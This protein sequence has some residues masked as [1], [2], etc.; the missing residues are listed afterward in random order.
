MDESDFENS[1]KHSPAKPAVAIDNKH[2]YPT[3]VLT[4]SNSEASPSKRLSPPVERDK[5]NNLPQKEKKLEEAGVTRRKAYAVIYE[6]LTAVKITEYRDAQG[7]VK[8]KETSDFERNKWGAE[9]AIK[10]FGD[11]IE[12]KEVEYDISDSALSKLRSLSVAELKARAA[13]ILLGKNATRIPP[14]DI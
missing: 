8:Y 9:M 3:V 1:V 10:M 5:I 4:P 14:V 13:D 11:A 6:A 12:R 7:N 2:A